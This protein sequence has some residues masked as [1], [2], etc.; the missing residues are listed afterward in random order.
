MH[1]FVQDEIEAT[2]GLF[3]TEAQCLAFLEKGDILPP[4][5]EWPRKV[6]D[7]FMSIRMGYVRQGVLPVLAYFVR[8]KGRAGILYHVVR[9][10][11][12]GYPAA[13]LAADIERALAALYGDPQKLNVYVTK[14]PARV[15]QAGP[16]ST[17]SARAQR[18]QGVGGSADGGDPRPPAPPPPPRVRLMAVSDSTQLPQEM[19][20]PT[21]EVVEMDMGEPSAD[22]ATQAGDWYEVVTI[23]DNRERDPVVRMQD[24]IDPD[25]IEFPDDEPPPILAIEGP[26]EEVI[27]MKTSRRHLGAPVWAFQ[28]QRLGFRDPMLAIEGP[29]LKRAVPARDLVIPWADVPKRIGFRPPPLAID[30]RVDPRIRDDPFPERLLSVNIPRSMLSRETE[31]EREPLAIGYRPQQLAIEYPR[32]ASLEHGG[33]MRDNVITLPAGTRLSISDLDQDAGRGRG[34]YVSSRQRAVKRRADDEASIKR[35][36][37]GQSGFTPTYANRLWRPRTSAPSTGGFDIRYK[38]TLRG[39]SFP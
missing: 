1:F 38:R 8:N 33:G 2:A 24:E 6:L 7:A 16:S 31:D 13:R 14:R 12:P 19:Q 11:V 20:E 26:R 3:R 17:S 21:Y 34:P 18:A 10:L 30:Y 9:V 22:P 23:P 32:T 4:M 35:P 29:P 25:R 37:T 5:Q 36:R 15:L 27:P 28:P 39:E